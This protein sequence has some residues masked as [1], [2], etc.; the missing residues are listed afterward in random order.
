LLRP[1]AE[2]L[3]TD[4]DLLAAK[5]D[6]FQAL[7]LNAFGSTRM[8]LSGVESFESLAAL[9]EVSGAF[10]FLALQQWVANPGFPDP[11]TKL[12]PKLG[13]AFGH[14]RNLNGPAPQWK[15]GFVTGPVPWMTGAGMVEQVRLGVRLPD[16]AEAYAWLEA[17]DRATFRHQ[18]PMP[19]IACSSTRTVRVE[20]CHLPLG[21]ADF[22]SRAARGTLGRQDA[23]SILFQTPLF[24]GNLRAALALILPNP[25]IEATRKQR[26]A[27]EVNR[28]IETIYTALSEGTHQ[29]TGG[30]LRAQAGD[31]AVR[32]GRLAAMA[33][34]GQSL[35]TSHPA[36]RIYRESLLFSLMAQTDAIVN[37][38]FEA[39]F[40]SEQGEEAK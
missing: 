28:L 40:V 1:E 23:E 25:R 24:L 38:A 4:A 37:H 7:G 29:E 20:I 17:D 12:W 31:L 30:R 6:L 39:V 21:E 33:C 11:G 3:D 34:G 16:G 15:D 36:Q 13:V 27:T 22:A 18:P 14:L 9:S 19:L 5:F 10:A 8:P 35:L 26:C 32:L 2:Q